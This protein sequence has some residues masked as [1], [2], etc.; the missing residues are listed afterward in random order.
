MNQQPSDDEKRYFG[1]IS[2]PD[3]VDLDLLWPKDFE[4]MMRVYYPGALE[5][6]DGQIG[7]GLDMH[8][9]W[10]M[11][12]AFGRA[13]G[14]RLRR[15]QA[16]HRCPRH[17]VPTLTEMAA[18]ACMP[19]ACTIDTVSAPAECVD[20]VLWATATAIDL[21][22][23]DC[24]TEDTIRALRRLEFALTDDRNASERPASDLVLA[25]LARHGNRIHADNGTNDLS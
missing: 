20:L 17:R 10:T 7:H 22:D 18:R 6:S 23:G 2:N 16:L 8:C 15:I 11:H 13:G 9:V 21:H 25:I 4:A 12:W 24:Q 19:S 5:K 1:A 14:P 3:V